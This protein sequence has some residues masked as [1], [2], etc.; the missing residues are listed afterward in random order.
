[1]SD[2]ETNDLGLASPAVPANASNDC[3]SA[4]ERE[5][6]E[7]NQQWRG[8]LLAPLLRWLTRIR[9][10][11][12]HITIVSTLVGL[13]FCPLYFVD[14]A[15]ALAAL[16]LHVLLDG[17]DG[18]LARFQQRAS[19]RGSFTDTMADQTI[20][21]ATTLTLMS[22]GAVN[23]IAGSVYLFVYTLVVAFAMIRNALEIPYS[24]LVR[25]RFVV[26]LWIAV[27]LYW[28]PG[29]LTWVLIVFDGLLIW[30]L[31]TGFYRLRNR[32]GEL[33]ASPAPAPAA[34]TQPESVE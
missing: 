12:D 29:S 14:P 13:A 31:L 15:W 33:E 26:Y 17:L 19:R 16:T 6:M 8:R 23:L 2:L 7:R 18:P 10:S 3:Y 1:M 24:W 25:P 5:A 34:V 22:A 32:L 4:G 30:K 28:L 21:F 9:V 20:I 11:P 27:E